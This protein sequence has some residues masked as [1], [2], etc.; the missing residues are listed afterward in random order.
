M[1]QIKIEPIKEVKS[2]F[3]VHDVLRLGKSVDLDPYKVTR[4]FKTLIEKIN[5]LI[6]VNKK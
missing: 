2:A 5:E 3:D 6:E 1:E 4:L